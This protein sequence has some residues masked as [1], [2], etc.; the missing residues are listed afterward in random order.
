MQRAVLRSAL[1]LLSQNNGPIITNFNYLDDYKT[2]NTSSITGWACPINLEK[3]TSFITSLDKL[4]AQLTQEVKL[5]EPWYHESMK[6]LKG[7]KLNG[8]T[9]YT[10]EELII[11]LINFIEDPNLDS[12]LENEPIERALKLASDDLK[13]FYFQAALARP[14]GASDLKINEWLYRR[15]YLGKTFLRIKEICLKHISKKLNISGK[16]NSV[17]NRCYYS[18]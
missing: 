2:Q 9:N 13:Y 5:L 8:L 16:T 17:P 11:F 15:T 12:F 3:P 4:A 10:N 18:L 14:N 7:R 1:E 6:N